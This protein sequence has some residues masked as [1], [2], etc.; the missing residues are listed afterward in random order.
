MMCVRSVRPDPQVLRSLELDCTT[1]RGLWHHQTQA[2]GSRPRT[3]E[4]GT[5]ADG[6]FHADPLFDRIGLKLR[7]GTRGFPEMLSSRLG[8]IELDFLPEAADQLASAHTSRGLVTTPMR[9]G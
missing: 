4:Q 3:A 1:G 8:L 7:A 2:G 5:D 6:Q 9:Q